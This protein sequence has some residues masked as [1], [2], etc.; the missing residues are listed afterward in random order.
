[1]TTLDLEVVRGNVAATRAAI[2]E[3][4]RRAGREAGAVE[5]L[6]ATKYVAAEDMPLLAEAGIE[7][8]GENRTDALAAKQALHAGLFAWDFIGALQ[9]R[10]ARD[11]VG[12]VEVELKGVHERPGHPA[13]VREHP[14]RP[15]HLPTRRVHRDGVAAPAAEP[16]RQKD[17][18][19]ELERQPP[20]AEVG[21]DLHVADIPAL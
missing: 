7:L 16:V 19:E 2:D 15:G 10:K 13:E 11:V 20:P 18:L 21:V 17:R 5:L 6:A 4:A 12:R 9:S 14:H 1:M 3:A 8:V